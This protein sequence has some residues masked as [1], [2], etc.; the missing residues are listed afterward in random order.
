MKK[1]FVTI[2]VISII[3]E[4]FAQEQTAKYWIFFA[5]KGISER[6]LS[7]ESAQIKQH[8][9]PR[10]LKRRQKMLPPDQLIDETDYPLYQPYL[11]ALQHHEIKPVSKSRWL[12]AISA[13]LGP[14]QTELVQSLSFVKKIQPVT[15]YRRR[16]FQDEPQS[17]APAIRKSSKNLYD[18][19][20]SF[21]Q[22]ELIHV[23]AVHQLGV[24]GE[25][26]LVGLL[27]TGYEYREHE[28][29]SELNVFD[30]YDFINKDT[31]TQNEDE[32][33][34]WSSQTDHGTKVLSI[35]G[36]FQESKLIGPA[37]GADFILGK[38]EDIRSETQIEEDYWVE[39]I[40]WME[41]QGVDVVNSSLGYNDWYTYED[42][43]G[44]T[45][46]TTI[47]ADIAVTKGVVV[48]NSNGNEGND[49]WRYMNAPA[50]GNNVISVGSV[51]GSGM[52]SF[53]SSLGPTYDGRIKPDVCAMGQQVWYVTLGKYPDYSNSSY[54]TSFSSPLTA[55][56]AALVLNAH[57]YLTPFQVR[58]A[59]RETAS[60]A[61]NPNNQIGW[62]IIN[63]YD[64]VFYHGMFFSPMPVVRTDESGHRVQIKIFS[65]NELKADSLFVYYSVGENTNFEQIPLNPTGNVNQYQAL[66]PL[67][68]RG[69]KIN[70]YFS[71]ADQSGDNKLHPHF[72]P[73]EIFF[74]HAYD[75]TINP[76][77]EPELPETFVLY[78]NYPNP[79]NNLTTIQFDL[80]EPNNIKLRIYNINGQ[81]VKT[82]VDGNRQTG[83]YRVRWDGTSDSGFAVSTGVYIYRLQAGNNL[84]IKKML[85]LR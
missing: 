39:G 22:N 23:P 62:G 36:G 10:A 58:D 73:D 57:P 69:A 71:A 29:F 30:E 54:G 26:V 25:G 81:L 78:D 56:V 7:K 8:I 33:G 27:D 34:D 15:Q 32:D 65:Q 43:D 77:D 60:N 13:Y 48:V 21:T 53:F 12:N 3:F 40:E 20:N 41:G 17:A 44:E 45:A 28:A 38:T 2:F 75:T 72:A 47:A 4:L 42:M 16:I 46:V 37:F 63:A 19:G 83:S 82:L 52:L 49:P 76:G 5:D 24:N 14:R 11:D 66:I 31:V 74:F 1:L 68:E 6:S 84:K 85:Y 70:I 50:D 61:S 79:F 67:Q 51:N 80:A 9:T 18:Y 64:A 35:V 59:L 55:G